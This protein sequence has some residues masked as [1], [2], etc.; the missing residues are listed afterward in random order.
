M[1]EK[2]LDVAEISKLIENA[3]EQSLNVQI[4]VHGVEL[5]KA[6][7]IAERIGGGH[8][9]PRISQQPSCYVVAASAN[10]MEVALFCPKTPFS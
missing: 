5:D 6:I 10:G 3:Q 9:E 8:R 4:N 1:S 7:E 2:K